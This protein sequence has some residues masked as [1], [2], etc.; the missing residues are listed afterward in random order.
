MEDYLLIHCTDTYYSVRVHNIHSFD[1]STNIMF[2]DK[3]NTAQTI[4]ES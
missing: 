3:P 2:L 4:C 1:I